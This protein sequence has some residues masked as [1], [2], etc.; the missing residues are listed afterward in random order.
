VPRRIVVEVPILEAEL[1]D[2]V[3]D[4]ALV[5][6]EDIEHGADELDGVGFSDGDPV[7]RGD[8]GLHE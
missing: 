6:F 5:S 2:D 1:S 3:H 8:F 7:A 4:G